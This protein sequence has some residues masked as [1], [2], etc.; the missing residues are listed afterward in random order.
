MARFITG[1]MHI[2]PAY[3]GVILRNEPTFREAYD[4]SRVCGG[5]PTFLILNILL[6]LILPAYAGVILPYCS[7]IFLLSYSSRVCGGDPVTRSHKITI[8]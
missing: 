4:S 3:A 2:L 6:D 1:I 8:F 5:D 7:L